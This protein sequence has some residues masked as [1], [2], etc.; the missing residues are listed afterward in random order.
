M[1]KKD[2]KTGLAALLESTTEATSKRTGT[3][4]STVETEATE[5]LFV[6]IPASLKRRFDVYCAEKKLKKHEAIAEALRRYLGI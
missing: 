1:A 4:V 5:G 6:S 2:Y 3:T